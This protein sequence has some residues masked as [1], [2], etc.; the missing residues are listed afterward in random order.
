MC[1][2]H[3]T[4]CLKRTGNKKLRFLAVRQICK[5]TESD[6]HPLRLKR[7]KKI[8][9]SFGF[10]EPV[11]SGG[12]ALGWKA[13]DIGSIPHFGSFLFKNCGF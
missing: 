11:W 6:S 9:E 2:I 5:I 10:S 12:K 3:I 7:E 1:T 4:S 13:D 8:F